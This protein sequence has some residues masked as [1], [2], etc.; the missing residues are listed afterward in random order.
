M[1]IDLKRH[2]EL[3]LQK[4]IIS[5]VNQLGGFVQLR[6]QTPYTRVGDPDIF[7]VIH[8]RHVEIEVK[9]P[10]EKP[11][12]IQRKRLREWADRGAWV[13]VVHSVEETVKMFML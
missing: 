6:A 5:A 9:W 3:A 12:L 10:G 7:G 8:R 4:R 13:G 11:S 2:R 1:T